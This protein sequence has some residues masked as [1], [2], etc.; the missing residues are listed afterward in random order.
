MDSQWQ[1]FIT[2]TDIFT[3]NF[4]IFRNYSDFTAQISCNL[5]RFYYVYVNIMNNTTLWKT[6]SNLTQF[7]HDNLKK[8]STQYGL[9]TNHIV[10]KSKCD[11]PNN[12]A[13]N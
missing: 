1:I 5:T 3:Y 13:K 4:M 7:R 6:N 10:K 12:D 11:L 8:E 9:G 2:N